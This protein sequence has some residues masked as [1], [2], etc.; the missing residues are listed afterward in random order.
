LGEVKILETTF[1]EIIDELE[2]E[3]TCGQYHVF[4]WNCNHF[5]NEM[6]KKLLGVPIPKWIMR[7]TSIL[8]FM[9][10]CLPKGIVSGQWALKNLMDE[11][12][13]IDE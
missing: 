12:E 7:T 6:A 4:E 11:Q 5:S 2:M 3:F 10:C 9:C 13:K 8:S 1:S